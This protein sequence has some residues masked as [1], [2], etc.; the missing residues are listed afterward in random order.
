MDLLDSPDHAWRTTRAVRKVAATPGTY[1]IVTGRPIFR[2]EY[3]VVVAI[4]SECLL[5]ISDI[6]RERINPGLYEVNDESR[7]G[8]L[9]SRITC[10]TIKGSEATT[11]WSSL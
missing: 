7:I 10:G 9:S 4:G 5:T 2:I 6:G 8:D 3:E 1:A 11:V